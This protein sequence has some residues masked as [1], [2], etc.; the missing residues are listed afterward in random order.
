MLAIRS[1]FACVF[2][3][4][5]CGLPA[6]EV[7]KPLPLG[8][9]ERELYLLTEIQQLKQRLAELEARLG[10]V[11]TS[12]LAG[13]SP[14]P[15]SD[16]EKTEGQGQSEKALTQ[17]KATLS[18]FRDTTINLT[19]DGYYAY[20]FNRPAGHINLLRAYDALSNSFSLNQATI[21]LERAPNLE[22]GRPYGVRV[23]LQY[24]QATETL[25]GS[26]ANESRPQVYRPVFQAY[27]TCLIPVGTGHTVDFGKWASALGIENN[28]SKD[29]MNYS[30]SYLFNYLPFYHFG[31]RSSYNLN[32]RLNINYWLVNGVQQSEDL[33]GF[34]SQAV[35]LTMKLA[36]SLSW[37]VNYF[38]GIEQA[39]VQSALNPG[40]PDI[41][42]QPG[43]SVNIIGH[44][45][46]RRQRIID[47]YAAW[48]ANAKLTLA[49]E[50][51]YVVHRL[52]NG[53]V[54]VTAGAAYARYQFTPKF[55]L[56]GRAE[57]F[58]D[59]GGLFSGVSQV[60]RECT[61]TAEYR[62]T[63]GFLLRGEWRRDFSDQPFF[64][65]KTPEIL[66][67]EQNTATRALIWWLGR[68]EGAW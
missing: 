48:N 30:R 57:Y 53:E 8:M 31:F 60:L 33:N 29:Q 1:L 51:D 12:T 40:L 34:K 17:D 50:F 36:G 3:I 11:P 58:S 46:G 26:A 37:N 9:T 27:G 4:C 52:K 35:L 63:D 16:R 68:K 38:E 55:A 62:V 24:G 56:A 22:A 54:H 6:E 14:Q 10:A 43:L 66:K 32:K 18:F 21:V 65:T 2:L 47:S 44:R 39:G 23:D 42:T 20:N 64:L 15:A 67:K 25:Q 49:G 59:R 41:A 13:A 19:L 7:K 45:P 61:F 28:Y 5:S